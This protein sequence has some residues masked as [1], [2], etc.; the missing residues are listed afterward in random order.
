MPT[1]NVYLPNKEDKERLTKLAEAAGYSSVSE[2]MRVMAK[3]ED[4]RYSVTGTR[5]I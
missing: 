5:N 1:I 4:K 2:Y 3:L